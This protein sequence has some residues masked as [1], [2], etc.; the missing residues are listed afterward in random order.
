MWFRTRFQACV[1]F[2][3]VFQAMSCGIHYLASVFMAVTPNF[4]CGFPGNVSSVL[5]HNS[6]A[7]SIEDIWTLWTSTE[8]YIVV[9]LENGE[10]WELDQCSRSKREVSLDLAYEYKGNKSVFPC[11]DGFLYD[12]TKWKSTVVTQW[13]L[14]CDREWLAK[15]I[16]P[17]FMLGVLIGAVIFG[18]I[19]DR[20][21]RQRVIW[22]TSAGQFVFGIAVAFTFDYYGFVIVR[23]L[24]AMVSSG[25]LV[26]AFVYV[27]EFV[28]I[29]ARTWASMHVHAFFAM[30]IMIVAL[31]GFFVRTWWVYQIF[32]TI[33]TL[34]FV[35]CCWMLPETPFWLLS[36]ERY[37][38][39]QKVIDTMARWNKVSTS[40]KVSELCSVQQDDL[41]RT[42]DNDTSSTKKHTILDLFCNWQIARRTITVWL[43][44]FTGSLGY[45]VFSLSSVSLG[46][47]EYLNLFLIGAVE[48]PCY[49][50]ACLAMDRLGRRNT[51]IPF[52]ILSAL[53]CVLIMFIPQDFNILIILANM[54]GKFSIGVAF[55]LIY[56]YTA[57]LYPTVV[58][59]LAVG[60]GS[61]MCRVGS[62]VAPFCVYLRSVWIFMPLNRIIPACTVLIPCE[63]N[64]SFA[65]SLILLH[66]LFIYATKKLLVGIMALLSGI[67]TIMLPETLG[68]PLTNTLVE[69]TEMGRNKKSCS[70]KTP[71]AHSG[72]ALEKIEMFGQERVGTDK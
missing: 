40:C 43:I 11:S 71:P 20:L 30:G 24:L 52:L 35:L 41:A 26:V 62:V 8:N 22:F 25:Y 21:G 56:L 55:G 4:V 65:H 42:G 29:K 3:S 68:K 60:S 57:E 17:T 5:F 53:I 49:I 38:D 18:D 13:D 59:S 45:Y 16:Q 44:W 48:L 9:Q 50:I 63:Q 32:L 46:G 23:F 27:T 66:N 47:N 19:A 34:P 2:A 72:A 36:E 54:A 70:E 7:S 1:Y 15:L 14:V 12:D 67:L 64:T 28:G 6:S 39:A 58:R 10:I 31:V 69:A 51:L 37:E 33:A 61:M